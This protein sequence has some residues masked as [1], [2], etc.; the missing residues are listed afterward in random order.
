MMMI[1]SLLFVVALAIIPL[2]RRYIPVKGIPYQDALQMETQSV[3]LDIRDYIVS[4][5]QPIEKAIEIPVPYLDRFFREIPSKDVHI[6]VSDRLEKNIG[7]RLLRKKG[8]NVTGYSIH[9]ST[10]TN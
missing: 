5:N 7:V 2:Y 6:I 4:A 8:F 3:R 10:C 1:Y 9:G